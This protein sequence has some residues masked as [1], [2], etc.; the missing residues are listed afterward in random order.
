[1]ITKNNNTA[2]KT[3]EEY[4]KEREEFIQEHSPYKVDEELKVKGY[5]YDDA[6]VYIPYRDCPISIYQLNIR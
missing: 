4:K 6:R 3:D 5:K 2:V 1:M